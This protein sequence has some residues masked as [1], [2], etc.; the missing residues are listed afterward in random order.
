[1]RC[2]I[3]VSLLSGA[4]LC[5]LGS[6]GYTQQPPM[7]TRTPR[8]VSN[9]VTVTKFDTVRGVRV[10]MGGCWVYPVEPRAHSRA[11]LS[12]DTRIGHLIAPSCDSMIQE[13]RWQ[14]DSHRSRDLIQ[15]A[16]FERGGAHS[17]MNGPCGRMRFCA[18]ARRLSSRRPLSPPFTEPAHRI[19]CHFLP[20]KP[21]R[22]QW[23]S[24]CAMNV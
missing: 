16:A 24:G 6:T 14:A 20:G 23:R 15:G 18:A 12:S 19:M 7:P 9:F 13:V 1:M 17:W 2:P 8:T 4:L 5:A 10:G 11:P 22:E 3:R 21:H